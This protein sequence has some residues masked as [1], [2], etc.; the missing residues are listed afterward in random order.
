VPCSVGP[1]GVSDKTQ[2]ICRAGP[3][4]S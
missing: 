2:G 4:R 1:H 3:R